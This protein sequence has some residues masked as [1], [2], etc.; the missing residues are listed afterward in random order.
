MSRKKRNNI[1]RVSKI[2][3]MQVT[4]S[5]TKTT[6]YNTKQNPNKKVRNKLQGKECWLRDVFRLIIAD[7]D[8]NRKPFMNYKNDLD[9]CLTYLDYFLICP[10]LEFF[11]GLSNLL[12][13]FN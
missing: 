5:L 3:V 2:T 8:R 1:Q 10:I 6:P 9:E 11:F 12:S 13:Y 4:Y 7:I